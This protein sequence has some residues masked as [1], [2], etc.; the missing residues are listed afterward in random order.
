MATEPTGAAGWIPA[1][2]G[3]AAGSGRSSASSRIVA[4]SSAPSERYAGSS[5]GVVAA[6][7]WIDAASTARKSDASIGLTGLGPW[8]PT[9]PGTAAP[10]SRAMSATLATTLG[11]RTSGGTLSATPT[12]RARG[13]RIGT[14]R[15]HLNGRRD[16]RAVHEAA[17]SA[18]QPLS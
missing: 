7:P 13:E 4:W 10:A 16:A 9:D 1:A 6:I 18:D 2:S 5:I 3:R 12:S 8:D 11:R 17:P 14:L 15:E